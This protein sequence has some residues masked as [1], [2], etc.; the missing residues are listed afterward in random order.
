MSDPRYTGTSKTGS[1]GS[2]NKVDA[3]NS[4]LQ[5]A[6]E[7]ADDLKKQASGAA[8]Y[9]TQQ[10]KDHASGL[11]ESAKGLASEAG[12]KLRGAAEGQKNAGADYISGVAGAVRRAAGEFDDQVPQAGQYIRLA[13]DQMENAADALRTRNLNELLG[14]VQ[15]FARRQPTAFIGATVLIGFALVRFFKSSTA[16]S[17]E[18]SNNFRPGGPGGFSRA[19]NAP[20]QAYP[21]VGAGGVSPQRR[22]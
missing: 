2:P 7:L 1:S 6:G 14:G 13:A 4:A 22:V 10:I 18:G 16:P 9:T 17:S 21:A 8:E 3:G 19:N 20:Q 15:D 11:A 5:Q 12:D